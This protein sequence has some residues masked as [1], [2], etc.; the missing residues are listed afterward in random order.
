MAF[1]QEHI[2]L[3][4][5][6]NY[7]FY[8]R[9]QRSVSSNSFLLKNIRQIV[10]INFT[11]VWCMLGSLEL[12]FI[13]VYIYTCGNKWMKPINKHYCKMYRNLSNEHIYT[14]LTPW[15]GFI[16][17][18][19]MLSLT[20]MCSPWTWLTIPTQELQLIF[21]DYEQLFSYLISPYKETFHSVLAS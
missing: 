21:T 7:F 1:E 9:F 16:T 17:S 11:T 13:V 5:S 15:L 12:F 10:S 6:I 19:L 4:A 8:N 20:L 14:N 18:T 2:V 3:S